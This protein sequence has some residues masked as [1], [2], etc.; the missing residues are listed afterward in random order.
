MS[1]GV[2]VRPYVFKQKYT[3]SG[4]RAP[5]WLSAQRRAGRISAVEREL[6]LRRAERTGI[7][8]YASVG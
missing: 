3:P 7:A 2:R 4:L 1:V 5:M 6:K 8:G